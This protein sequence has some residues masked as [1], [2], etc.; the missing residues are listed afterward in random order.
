M[1]R[2]LRFLFVPAVLAIARPGT[3]QPTPT[4]FPHAVD[5]TR[6]ATPAREGEVVV[7]GRRRESDRYRIPIELRDHGPIDA[8]SESPVTAQREERSLDQ[9][10]AQTVGPGGY[11]QHS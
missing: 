4:I 1:I 5:D 7:C 9:F 11:L 10:G 2:A 3:T 8:R 6:C